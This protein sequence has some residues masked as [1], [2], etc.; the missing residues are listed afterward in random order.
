MPYPDLVWAAL[1]I[2]GGYLL[3]VKKNLTTK[4]KWGVGLIFTGFLFQVYW[5]IL[6]VPQE[7][8]L[9]WNLDS[10]LEVIYVTL[11]VIVPMFIWPG[12]RKQIFRKKQSDKKK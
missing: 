12:L 7:S 10:Q 4:E 2:I 8:A 9:T 3:I 1:G 5:E 6:H 11:I